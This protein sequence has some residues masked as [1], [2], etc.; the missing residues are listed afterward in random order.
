MQI[1]RIEET[2]DT[3]GRPECFVSGSTVDPLTKAVV[4]FAKWLTAAEYARYQAGEPLPVILSGFAAQ[5][6]AANRQELGQDTVKLMALD[7]L[8]SGQYLPKDVDTE[9]TLQSP[10]GEIVTVFVPKGASFT[11]P[12][13]HL[14]IAEFPVGV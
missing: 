9:Y 7:A 5:R 8:S 2:T 4:P 14:F 12:A 6:V 11:L 10:T 1:D 13:G 3:Q